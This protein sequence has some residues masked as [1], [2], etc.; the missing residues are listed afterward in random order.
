[1]FRFV[2]VYGFVHRSVSTRMNAVAGRAC[3]R[4]LKGFPFLHFSTGYSMGKLEEI[5]TCI[6]KTSE[7]NKIT[8]GAGNTP[9]QEGSF[10]LWVTMPCFFNDH[11]FH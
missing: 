11:A 10:L 1:M 2:I 5:F 7:E 3:H 4:G 8:G 6:S 9:E